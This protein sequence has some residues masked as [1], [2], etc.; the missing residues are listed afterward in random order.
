MIQG[1]I[2]KSL[3]TNEQIDYICDR[4]KT[5]IDIT[6]DRVRDYL[7]NI[8]FCRLNIYF[9]KLPNT[10]FSKV[11]KYYELDRKLRLIILDAIER[12]EI[13]IKAVIVNK[14]CS[15]YDSNPVWYQDKHRFNS[16][17]SYNNFTNIVNDIKIKHRN[18]QDIKSYRRKYSDSLPI[19]LLMEKFSFGDVSKLY[20]FLDVEDAQL[21]AKHFGKT[22]ENFKDHLQ[23]LT[24]IRNMCAHH[25]NLFDKQMKLK[26]RGNKQLY[27]PKD[28]LQ[29]LGGYLILVRHYM[30]LIIPSSS[31]GIRL[32]EL[33]INYGNKHELLLTFLGIDKKLNE[34][35]I[36]T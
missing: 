5:K 26:L 17:Q 33:L 35:F 30:N 25:V 6:N 20:S 10:N 15:K 7:T 14:L 29:N 2:Q 13:S 28:K 18:E 3:S 1:Y 31:W 23:Y 11:I 27:I 36:N 22:T 32:K 9:Q 24:Y 19:W 12:I 34:H 16:I 8:S 21:I 4:Y